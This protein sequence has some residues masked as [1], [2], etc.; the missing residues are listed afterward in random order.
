MA[1]FDDREKIEEIVKEYGKLL[2]KK[3]KVRHLYLYGSYV[4]DTNSPDK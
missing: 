3:I 4:K 2:R 1:P